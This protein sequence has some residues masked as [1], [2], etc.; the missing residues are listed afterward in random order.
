M[1]YYNIYCILYYK[2]YYNIYCI[3]FYILLYILY[4]VNALSRSSAQCCSS[5]STGAGRDKRDAGRTAQRGFLPLVSRRS[6]S[7]GMLQISVT[8]GRGDFQVLW[9]SGERNCMYFDRR[10][11]VFVSKFRYCKVNTRQSLCLLSLTLLLLP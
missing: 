6:A 10:I 8:G 1:I 11:S 7:S 3:V 9:F 2:I 5:C 4:S